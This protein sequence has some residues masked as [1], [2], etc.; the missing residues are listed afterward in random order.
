VLKLYSFV[1]RRI[2]PRS[3]D[4]R[5]PLAL[6][7]VRRVQNLIRDSQP[8][9]R[10]VSDDVRF[11]D[12]VDIFRFHSAI[13]HAFRIDDN[14]GAK[15]ALVKASRLICANKLYAALLELHLEKPL[16]F[17]LPR[18]IATWPR[19]SRFSLIHANENVF[20]EF[21]HRFVHPA[22]DNSALDLT[23]PL[24]ELISPVAAAGMDFL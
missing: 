11:D 3:A 8:F 1:A 6:L 19:M 21:R 13:P 9:H 20:R 7:F 15:F 14:V 4:S 12:F 24:C 17:P 18:R 22:K 10:L 2:I 16:Q 23:K 5:N